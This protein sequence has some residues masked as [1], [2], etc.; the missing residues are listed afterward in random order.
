MLFG[1]ILLGCMVYTDVVALLMRWLVSTLMAGLS[2]RL[3][4]A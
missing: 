1:C 2:M 4:W 3:F